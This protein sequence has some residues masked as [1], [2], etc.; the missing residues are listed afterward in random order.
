MLF[1]L[2]FYLQMFDWIYSNREVFLANY[3]DIGRNHSLASKLQEE[4]LQFTVA[5]NV[6]M[7]KPELFD[8]ILFYNIG[9]RPGSSCNMLTHCEKTLKIFSI[10]PA[11]IVDVCYLSKLK[12][13]ILK[14]QPPKFSLHMVMNYSKPNFPG[15]W[16]IWLSEWC[17]SFSKIVSPRHLSICSG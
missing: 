3:V 2:L 17:P 10:F 7:R 4:H 14:F 6:S 9:S 16:Q 13:T 11:I 12:Q 5:S 8:R 15:A 1:C